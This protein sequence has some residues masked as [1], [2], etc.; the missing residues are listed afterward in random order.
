[1]SEQWQAEQDKLEIEIK[2]H[3]EADRSHLTDGANLI[4]LAHDAARLFAKQTP[5]Q[6]RQLLDFVLSNST[7]ANGEL[8]AAFRQP[9][10]IIAKTVAIAASEKEAKSQK[11]FEHPV[12]LTT[13]YGSNRSGP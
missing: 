2:R 8:K 10:D 6:K 11:A 4:D 1:M 9:F 3:R 12:W 13:Q 7:Y 5:K